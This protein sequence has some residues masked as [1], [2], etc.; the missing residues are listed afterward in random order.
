MQQNEAN[1]APDPAPAAGRRVTVSQ[2]DMPHFY[3]DDS[4]AGPR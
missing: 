1:P 2:P 3:V 4:V